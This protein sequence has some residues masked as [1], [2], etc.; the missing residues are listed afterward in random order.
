MAT[1]L[2]ELQ[3]YSIAKGLGFVALWTLAIFAFF[4]L[5]SIYS[6]Y[7]LL[8]TYDKLNSYNASEEKRAQ[9]L[10]SHAKRMIFWVLG[11]QGEER[12][13][14]TLD[15][16]DQRWICSNFGKILTRFAIFYFVYI[17]AL[18]LTTRALQIDPVTGA[19]R[20]LSYT[21]KQLFGF[22][23]IGLYILSNSICDIASIYFTVKHLEKVR[24]R[25]NISTAAFY[26]GKNLIYCFA[27]FLISQLFSNF[28]WPLKTNLDIPELDRLFSPAIALWP[29]AF[30][31]DASV[32]S[33]K[34]LPLIFPGQL[35]ITGTVFLPTLVTVF[36]ISVMAISNWMLKLPKKYIEAF[37][38]SRNSEY[39]RQAIDVTMTPGQPP[40]IEYRC[41]NGIAATM[42]NG[43][44][45]SLIATAIWELLKKMVS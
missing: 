35:L 13:R 19:V 27:F 37:I 36:I 18:I 20:V 7:R 5:L 31:L 33:P 17:W 44:I 11:Y 30:I 32:S 2:L 39:F 21:P 43:V 34:Y 15:E 24:E 6:Q 16:L 23:M 12:E 40:F 8:N 9:V 4:L 14:Q 26:L 45:S 10:I 41:L 29:Y 3:N 22:G 28:I 38:R 1:N 25:P 42:I